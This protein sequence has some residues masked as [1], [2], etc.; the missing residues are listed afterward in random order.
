M[1]SL[2][3]PWALLALPLPF[4]ARKLLPE[5]SQLQDAGLRVPSLQSPGFCSSLPRRAPNASATNSRCPYPV[6]T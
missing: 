1:W 4:L 5:S 6:A 3:W 2:A